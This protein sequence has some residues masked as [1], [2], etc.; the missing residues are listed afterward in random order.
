MTQYDQRHGGAWDRGSADSYYRRAYRP[1]YFVGNT[2][3]SR[4]VTQ[5]RMTQ[6]E[7]DAYD[8]GFEYNER[9]GDHKDY[10]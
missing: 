8:A 2:M 1:H 5:D 4:E 9:M 6:A 3:Q 10:G 7:L